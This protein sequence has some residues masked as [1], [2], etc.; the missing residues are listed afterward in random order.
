MRLEAACRQIA[1]VVKLARVGHPFVD[2]DQAGPV[3]VHQL[4]QYVARAGGALVIGADSL[5]GRL[6]AELPGQLAPQR[7]DDRAVRL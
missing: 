7:A 1:L 5:E 3:V 2:Q 4:A 6:A